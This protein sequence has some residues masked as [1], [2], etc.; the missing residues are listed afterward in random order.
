MDPGF[1][2]PAAFRRVLVREL[3]EP[4]WP[5][6]PLPRA[7]AAA[8]PRRSAGDGD[9]ELPWFFMGGLMKDATGLLP[10]AEFPKSAEEPPEPP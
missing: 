2:M 8:A 4:L 7:A 3:P 6:N 10:E 1:P 9:M 5:P